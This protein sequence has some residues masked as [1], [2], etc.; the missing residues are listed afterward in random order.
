MVCPA[1]LASCTLLLRAG[2]SQCLRFCLLV[3]QS[4]YLPSLCYRY[5][6]PVWMTFQCYDPHGVDQWVD[7]L[8][9][10]MQHIATFL[11]VAL[12]LASEYKKTKC[13]YL[14]VLCWFRVSVGASLKKLQQCVRGWQDVTVFADSF[15]KHVCNVW[16]MMKIQFVSEHILACHFH[17]KITVFHFSCFRPFMLQ[18]WYTS[19]CISSGTVNVTSLLCLFF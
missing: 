9:T 17:E 2:L 1:L 7:V 8:F 14:Y 18:I 6:S 11:C 5:I 12:I 3:V 19:W 10:G 16:T 13:K 4:D 15:I